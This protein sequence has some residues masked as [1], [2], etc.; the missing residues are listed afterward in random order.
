VEKLRL[1]PAYT[2][3][4]YD[5]LAERA[6]AFGAGLV[7]L[8]G[9]KAHDKLVIYADTRAE[10]QARSACGTAARRSALHSMRR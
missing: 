7:A 1:A 6:S 2:W 9:L 4:T 3:L 8:A 10:W 5:E